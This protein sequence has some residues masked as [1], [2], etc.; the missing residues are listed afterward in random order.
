VADKKQPP[1]NG[2]KKPAPATPSQTQATG[3]RPPAETAPK[4]KSNVKFGSLLES[5]KTGSG[6][7]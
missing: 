4:P 1:A 3:A 2:G 5:D 7:K 6:N